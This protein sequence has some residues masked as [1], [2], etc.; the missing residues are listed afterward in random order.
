[1]L[2]KAKLKDL[3]VF[4]GKGSTFQIWNPAKFEDYMAQAK[5]DAKEKRNLLRLTK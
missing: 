4:V 2:K 3:A 5:K 1:L